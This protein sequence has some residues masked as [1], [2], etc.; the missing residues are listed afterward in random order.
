VAKRHTISAAFNLQVYVHDGDK[1]T[2]NGTH[3]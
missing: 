1:H 3:T 2:N